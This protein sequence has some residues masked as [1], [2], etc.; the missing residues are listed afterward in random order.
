MK[1]EG[2]FSICR[3]AGVLTTLTCREKLSWSAKDAALDLQTLAATL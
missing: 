2:V 1:V 3:L